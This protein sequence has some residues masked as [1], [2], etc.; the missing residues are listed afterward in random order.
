[1][2]IP[3][4]HLDKVDYYEVKYNR[5]LFGGRQTVVTL[6]YKNGRWPK[7][8]KF[9]WLYNNEYWSEPDTVRVLQNYLIQYFG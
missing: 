8:F 9:R 1:M 3:K 5:N 4:E 2:I 7:K 6:H